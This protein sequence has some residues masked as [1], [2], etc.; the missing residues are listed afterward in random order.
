MSLGWVIGGIILAAM[1]GGAYWIGR[2][3]NPV[4]PTIAFVPQAA[5]AAR[6]LADG[7]WM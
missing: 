6:V 2:R 4:I 5:G 3:T 1:T 7:V